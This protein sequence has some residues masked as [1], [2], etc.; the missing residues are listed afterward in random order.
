LAIMIACADRMVLAWRC[1]PRITA[2]D[3]AEMLREAVV[4]RFGEA[5]A[6][7]HGREVLNDNGPE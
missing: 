3:L 2:E 6:H 7:A 1:A 5:R 4:R